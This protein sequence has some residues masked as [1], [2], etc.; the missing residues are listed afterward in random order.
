MPAAAAQGY[1]LGPVA[2]RASVP[3]LVYIRAEYPV[4][5]GR[6]GR[7]RA[8]SRKDVSVPNG[9]GPSSSGRSSTCTG[10]HSGLHWKSLCPA[11]V[12][13]SRSR[14]PRDVPRSTDCFQPAHEALHGHVCLRSEVLDV[15]D[16]LRGLQ[17]SL[18]TVTSETEDKEGLLFLGRGDVCY[19]NVAVVLGT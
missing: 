4:G 1:S 13:P 19:T 15:R 10:K 2:I 3:A 17:V 7:N 11:E 12:I 18:G 16:Q 9:L 8:L 14:T 6:F 5:R